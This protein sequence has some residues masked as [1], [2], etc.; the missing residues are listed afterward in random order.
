MWIIDLL[1]THPS[2]QP[3]AQVRRFTHEV[4]W[5]KEHTPTPYAFA[6]FTFGLA[7]ESIKEFGG[8]LG[9]D[10]VKIG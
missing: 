1:V 9:M 7:V 2:P 4:L 5:I 8:A 6:I 10:I 3:R